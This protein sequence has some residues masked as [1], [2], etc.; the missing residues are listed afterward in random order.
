MPRRVPLPLTFSH[1]GSAALLPQGSQSLPPGFPL[2]PVQLVPPSRCCSLSSWLG[3]LSRVFLRRA[4][5]MQR[6][7]SPPQAESPLLS[8]DSTW[9]NACYTDAQAR[10]FPVPGRAIF[11]LLLRPQ[12]SSSQRPA[13]EPSDTPDPTSLHP[14]LQLGLQL[15][16]PSLPEVSLSLPVS[17]ALCHQPSAS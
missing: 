9:V 5:C 13:P 2:T 17:Q 6:R 16:S 4:F 15:L 7:P 1:P 14:L 3:P 12:G 11:H 10:L 8:P